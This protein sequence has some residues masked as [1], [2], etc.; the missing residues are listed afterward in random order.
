MRTG[1]LVLVL[2]APRI[3]RR[4]PQELEVVA[5]KDLAQ[6]LETR[7]QAVNRNRSQEPHGRRDYAT[8][9]APVNAPG[10][11][12]TRGRTRDLCPRLRV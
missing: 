4:R 7:E 6:K 1:R 12:E 2:V 10:C 3:L 9:R 5:V 11:R 8:S